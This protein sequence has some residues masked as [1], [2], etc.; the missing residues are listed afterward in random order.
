[1]I[2]NPDNIISIQK[3]H[4]DVDIILAYRIYNQENPVLQLRLWNIDNY[5]KCGQD[6]ILNARILNNGQTVKIDDIATLEINKGYGQSAVKK[7]IEIS[8]NEGCNEII[9]DLGYNDLI[10]HKERLLHFYEKLGFLIQ[11]FEGQ[12]EGKIKL[13]I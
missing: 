13:K 8:K 10:D 11:I 6:L 12:N 4:R 3:T 5:N 2:E 1:L 9:G 7:L